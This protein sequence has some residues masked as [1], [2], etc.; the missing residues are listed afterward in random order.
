MS[1]RLEKLTGA[2]SFSAITMAG[3]HEE[4]SSIKMITHGSHKEPRAIVESGAGSYLEQHKH[5]CYNSIGST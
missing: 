3:S 2:R 4:P 5:R 1:A